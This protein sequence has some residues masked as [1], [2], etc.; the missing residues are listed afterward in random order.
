M[1]LEAFDSFANEAGN[2]MPRSTKRGRM[3]SGS[4]SAIQLARMASRYARCDGV[5]KMPRT[6]SRGDGSTAA[7]NSI[8]DCISLR[9][10]SLG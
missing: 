4:A 5:V 7:Q 10:R 2:S 3:T 1:S 6:A 8:M 9:D